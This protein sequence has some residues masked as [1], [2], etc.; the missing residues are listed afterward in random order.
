MITESVGITVYHGGSGPIRN[1]IETPFFTTTHLEMAR[2]YARVK[3]RGDGRITQFEISPSAQIASSDEAEK[4]A[5]T[6]GIE[7]DETHIS[8]LFY[9]GRDY[10]AEFNLAGVMREQGYDAVLIHDFGYHSDF[11]EEPTYIV[12]NAD[13]LSGGQEIE[14]VES[15]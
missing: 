9:T 13:V 14:R 1:P 6:L 10:H 5:A 7:W 4:I 2:S 3:G 11:A 12:L 8:D 15:R